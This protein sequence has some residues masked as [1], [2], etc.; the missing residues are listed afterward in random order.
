MHYNVDGKKMTPQIR[1]AFL[2]AACEYLLGARRP[3]NAAFA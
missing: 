1:E 2:R 3:A